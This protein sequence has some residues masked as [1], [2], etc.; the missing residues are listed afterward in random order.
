[1]TLSAL[2]PP[3][4]ELAKHAHIKSREQYDKLYKQSLEDPDAFWSE[5]AE[6]FHWTKRWKSPILEYVP[7]GLYSTNCPHFVWRD[8][9]ISN[10][11]KL[12]ECVLNSKTSCSQRGAPSISS[13]RL[14]LTRCNLD[15][16]HASAFVLTRPPCK[17]VASAIPLSSWHC[18]FC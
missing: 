2:Y 1:M 3:P 10:A 11:R 8:E 13:N 17:C 18:S 7:Q 12:A 16:S 15:P 14:S 6:A 9:V 5:Q 4:A